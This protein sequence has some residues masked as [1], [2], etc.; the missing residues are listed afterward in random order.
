MGRVPKT[1]LTGS[2]PPSRA[3]WPQT[4]TTLLGAERIVAVDPFLDPNEAW[5][6]GGS[7]SYAK[8]PRAE[9]EAEKRPLV[10]SFLLRS[11][12]KGKVPAWAGTDTVSGPSSGLSRPLGS[13]EGNPP[14]GTFASIASSSGDVPWRGWHLR[15]AAVMGPPRNQDSLKSHGRFLFGMGWRHRLMHSSGRMRGLHQKSGRQILLGVP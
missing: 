8:C 14:N 15:T 1:L 2:Y 3:N 10:S 4:N 9:P 7:R 5:L 13:R 6:S 11:T 12:V